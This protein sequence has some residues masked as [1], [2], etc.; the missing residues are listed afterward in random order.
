MAIEDIKELGAP[1]PAPEYEPLP[2]FT[3]EPEKK[4]EYSSRERRHRSRSGRADRGPSHRL[5][6]T[7]R[8][9]ARQHHRPW[10]SV[11]KRPWRS[12]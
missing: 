6:P 1:K 12:R 7:G 10:L 11:A 8:G 3:P 4:E 9:H 5:S 2:T